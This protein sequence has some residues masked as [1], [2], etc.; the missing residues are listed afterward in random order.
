MKKV[1]E[2]INVSKIDIT[3]GDTV[4]VHVKVTEA[5][6]E[7]IQIFEGIV[8]AISGKGISK[9]MTVRKV[10]QGIG[11]ERIFPLSSPRIKKIELTEKGNVG[12]AKL[13]YMRKRIGKG[14]LDVQ[15][16]EDFTGEVDEMSGLVPDDERVADKAGLVEAGDD[17]PKQ[18]DEKVKSKKE[19]KNQ[20]AA[21]EKKNKDVKKDEVEKDVE[22][23]K[24]TKKN[25]SKA[26]E[27]PDK[28]K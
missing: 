8:I 28:S 14:S 4:R 3:P 25:G 26:E 6:K 1:E 2:K 5:G 13:Y 12:R 9:S 15:L 16:D 21:R 23:E 17:V 20:L 24:N 11:V 19:E 10:S 22:G 7:R 27:K 18:E